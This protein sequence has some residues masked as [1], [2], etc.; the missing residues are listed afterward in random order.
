M[1]NLKVEGLSFSIAAAPFGPLMRHPVA[2]KAVK[3][4]RLS[5]S[6]KVAT[7]SE[8]GAALI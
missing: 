4:C 3:I 8:V 1:R 7:F 5:A 6:S 2:S